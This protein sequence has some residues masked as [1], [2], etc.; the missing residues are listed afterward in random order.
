MKSKA[1]GRSNRSTSSREC[2]AFDEVAFSKNLAKLLVPANK[3]KA[4]RER[5]ARR[6]LATLDTVLKFYRAL[7]YGHAPDQSTVLAPGIVG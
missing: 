7:T 5:Q 2:E 6:A 4:I 1:L 3:V